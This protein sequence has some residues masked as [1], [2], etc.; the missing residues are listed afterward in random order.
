MKRYILIDGVNGA[1]KTTLFCTNHLWK[2]MSRINIDE[3]VREIGSWQD[4]QAVF[5]AGKRAIR[6][7]DDYFRQ[8]VSF[9]QETTLCGNS[10]LENIDRARENGYTIEL[11]YVGLDSAETAIQRVACRVKDGG[12]GVL[13]DDVRRRY[14]VSLMRLKELLPVFD[15]AEVYDNTNRLVKLAGYEKGKQVYLADDLPK[16]FTDTIH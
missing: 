5:D 3:M 1:G 6:V 10:I 2:S 15:T 16:W 9:N 8:G 12:H 14:K 13:D 7:I 4:A 11:Y